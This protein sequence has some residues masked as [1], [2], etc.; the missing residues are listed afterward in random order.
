MAGSSLADI[1]RM[2]RLSGL[3]M[4]PCAGRTRHMFSFIERIFADA[5][6]Q[7]PK[8]AAAIARTGSW[9]IEVRVLAE[10][11]SVVN[12]VACAVEVQTAISAQKAALTTRIVGSMLD[13]GTL[14]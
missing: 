8:L 7:G 6:Y 1:H 5:N 11:P 14:A 10:I 2:I 13:R 3:I 4:P 9:T 12:A